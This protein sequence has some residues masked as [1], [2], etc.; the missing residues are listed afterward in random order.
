MAKWPPA[1]LVLAGVALSGGFARAQADQPTDAPP[2]GPI[3]NVRWYTLETPH[4]EIHYYTEE[5][6]FAERVAHFAERAYR[7][8]TRYLN[9]RP[10]GHVSITLNDH[11]DGANG[12]ASSVP[13]NFIY[14]FGS[15]PDALD[16][17]SEFDDY[18]KLLISHEFTHVVHLDTILSLCPRAINTVLGKVYA[19]NLA[20]PTWFIE[21][22][23]VL[24]ARGQ[25]LRIVSRCTTCVN[26]CEI[27]SFT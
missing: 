14:A 27:S 20:Q 19:P 6:A 11:T 4:F 24:I 23:A 2:S 8:N 21:G 7:L 16:E 9:W 17:L 18:V 5:R 1:A 26:S 25:R 12:F 3:P 10:N 13:Y 22:L 15:P